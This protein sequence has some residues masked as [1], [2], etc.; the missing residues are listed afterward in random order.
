MKKFSI[1]LSNWKG[2]SVRWLNN[3]AYTGLGLVAAIQA[4]EVMGYPLDFITDQQKKYIVLSV[5][6]FKFIEKMTSP[7]NTDVQQ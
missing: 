7:R 6:L 4:A 5:I 2:E 3:V 1:K